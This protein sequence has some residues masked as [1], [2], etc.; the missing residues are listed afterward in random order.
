M[1]LTVREAR[2]RAGLSRADVAHAMGMPEPT[3]RKYERN[4][5]LLPLHK[6]VALARVL[7]VPFMDLRLQNTDEVAP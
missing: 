7:G 4:P 5:E 6:S 3:Y 1:P 2:E